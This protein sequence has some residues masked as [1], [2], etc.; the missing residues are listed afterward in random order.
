MS[1][2]TFFLTLPPEIRNQIYELVLPPRHA[3]LIVHKR[4]PQPASREAECRIKR[5][6]LKFEVERKH[7]QKLLDT[8][9]ESDDRTGSTVN[10]VQNSADIFWKKTVQLRLE[11]IRL[12]KT[13]LLCIKLPLEAHRPPFD[14]EFVPNNKAILQVSRQVR[15]ETIIAYYDRAI[16]LSPVVYLGLLA[17]CDYIAAL[18]PKIQAI[19]R[20]DISKKELGNSASL[21]KDLPWPVYQ[22]VYKRIK[23]ELIELFRTD[24]SL[25][26]FE[27]GIYPGGYDGSF[28]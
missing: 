3:P 1:D 16:A 18:D 22:E 26:A 6:L 4:K 21:V 19:V 9:K 23:G 2:R 8:P 14:I 20:Q 25:W 28:D 17:W 27:N 11:R 24:L 12:E 7:L 15:A 13:A 10:G 5:L